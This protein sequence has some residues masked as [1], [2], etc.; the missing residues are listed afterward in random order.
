MMGWGR[1]DHAPSAP[2]NTARIEGRSRGGLA[3][4]KKRI[5]GPNERD[6]RIF[7][8]EKGLKRKGPKR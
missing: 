2:I 4:K 1:V 3:G 6:L 5:G 7:S 8:R